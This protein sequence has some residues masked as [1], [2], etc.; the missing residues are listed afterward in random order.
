M[1]SI[2]VSEQNKF[3]S[4][5]VYVHVNGGLNENIDTHTHTLQMKRCKWYEF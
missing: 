5:Y 2:R 4:G 3:G 1:L